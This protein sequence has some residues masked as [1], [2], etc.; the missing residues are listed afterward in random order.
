ML[1][2]SMKA[3]PTETLKFNSVN[4]TRRWVLRHGLVH[5]TISDI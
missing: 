4:Y 1:P 3:L 2:L 5:Q